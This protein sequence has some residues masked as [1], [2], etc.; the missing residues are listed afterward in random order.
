MGS[1]LAAFDSANLV[2]L[3]ERHWAR[4]DSQFRLA[5]IRNLAQK[6]NDIVVEFG[7]PRYQALPDSFVDGPSPVHVVWGCRPLRTYCRTETPQRQLPMRVWSVRGSLF[8]GWPET[9]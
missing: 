2:A 6:V 9:K 3:G 5:L 7:N 8:C 1:V 4:E